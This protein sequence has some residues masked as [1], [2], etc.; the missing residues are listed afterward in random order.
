MD[1]TICQ[2]EIFD[3]RGKLLYIYND[4][5]HPLIQL[6]VQHLQPGFYIIRA[7]AQNIVRTAKIIKQ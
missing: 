3:V 6:P 2:V 7:K 5:S 4:C 1:M